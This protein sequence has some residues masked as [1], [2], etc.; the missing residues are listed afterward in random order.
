MLIPKLSAVFIH[1][2][3][4][5]YSRKDIRRFLKYIKVNRETGCWEWRGYL[6][7]KGY[8]RLTIRKNNKRNFYLVHRMA[9][10]I[11]TNKL[12]PDGMFVCHHCDNPK[13][14]NVLVC[15][16]LGTNKDNM[17]DM[18]NKGRGPDRCGENSGRAKLTWVQVGEIRRLYATGKYTYKQLGRIYNVSC[19]TIR[20][21]IINRIWKYEKQYLQ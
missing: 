16:F 3:N 5:K 20:H 7:K 9:Y 8:G 2:C 10:E 4:G 17:A 14:V 12:I 19:T 11:F 18:V 1:I 13:C 6:D 21:I 15:L